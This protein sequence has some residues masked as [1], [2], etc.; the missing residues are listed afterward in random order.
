MQA[1]RKIA[2]IFGGCWCIALGSMAE[3]GADVV[4]RAVSR[5]PQP[6][7]LPTL[8]VQ[9]E[10]MWGQY[11]MMLSATFPNVPGYQSDAWC[12]ES[13][14]DYVDARPLDHGAIEFRH[15]DSTYPQA[16]VVTVVTPESGAIELVARMELDR[17][18]Y[19]DAEL[20]TKPTSLNLCWQLRHAKGF[21]SAPDPYPE[22]VRRCFLYTE[23]GR[24]FLLDLNRRKIPPQPSDHK[25]NNPPWVQS[26]VGIWQS[27]PEV[28]ATSWADYSQDRYI[29]TI[30]GSVSRDGNYLTAIG[31]DSS[32]TM[33]QAWHDCMHNNPQW[34]PRNAPVEEQRWRLKIYAMK[35]DS[36]ALLKRF[37][38]D[39]PH[40]P[41]LKVKRD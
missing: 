40:A 20:P 8:R 39:F 27:I 26:Y 15:R 33:C 38:K 35:N 11:Y 23:T 1:Y 31:N 13:A 5:N 22:F 36:D 19:P 25:Y 3:E 18:G 12:Y 2:L 29:T 34:L 32:T 14:V 17:D 6:G 21:A 28:S 30:I 4:V 24:S 7:V 41:H 16:L 37:G 9:H 10:K